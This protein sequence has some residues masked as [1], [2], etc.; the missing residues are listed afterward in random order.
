MYCWG[1]NT[2]GQL[3]DGTL[4]NRSIPVQ[5]KGQGGSGNLV[6]VDATDDLIDEKYRGIRPA[7][8][9]PACP[10]HTEKSKLFDLL[11][12]EHRIG[13]RLTESF[14][15]HPAASVCGLYFA[16]P[17]S[18]YFAVDKLDRDQVADYAQ[19]KG[20]QLAEA[21]R[22]LGPWLNYEAAAK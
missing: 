21:E 12:A 6:G 18:V 14:A 4:A 3:G 22:W 8:G 15:M 9:Y 19:R 1:L 16:H 11:D 2:N 7:H 13:I 20:M 5:V 10:D 17:R